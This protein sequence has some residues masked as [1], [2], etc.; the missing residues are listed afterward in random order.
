MAL[1]GMS[2]PAFARNCKCHINDVPCEK[3]L[4]TVLKESAWT[5]NV[6]ASILRSQ[7][8]LIQRSRKANTV[9]LAFFKGSYAK[10][11]S[12]RIRESF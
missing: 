9:L 5:Q 10:C 3:S 4:V 12:L 2:V 6:F 7:K 11:V 8:V 1:S